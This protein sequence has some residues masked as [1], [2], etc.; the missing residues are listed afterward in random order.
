M[1]CHSK[2]NSQFLPELRLIE[3]NQHFAVEANCRD[4][5]LITF[6]LHFL[7]CRFVLD[8]I[9]FLVFDAVVI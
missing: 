1:A 5:Q 9:K 2:L 8:Y 6:I 3:P 7:A 4:R